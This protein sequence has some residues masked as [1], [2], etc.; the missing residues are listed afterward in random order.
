MLFR[1]WNKNYK[2]FSKDKFYYDKGAEKKLVLEKL[3]SFEKN[4]LK[5]YDKMYD[6]GLEIIRD[7]LIEAFEKDTKKTVTYLN[8]A[9]VGK[10]ESVPLLVIKAYGTNYKILTDEDD[11]A[12]FLPKTKKV[13]CTSSPTSKQDF[14]IELI[15]T[16]SDKMIL[17]FAVRT[18]KVGDEHKLGQFFNLAVKFNGV[19]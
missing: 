10:D 11:V 13:K 16:P 17:K 2:N 18:N 12:V 8:R 6:D 15:S 1:S 5:A 3:A 9:I 14:F 7:T 19:K 4:D